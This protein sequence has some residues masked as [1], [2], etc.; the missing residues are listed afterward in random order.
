MSIRPMCRLPDDFAG[1][2]V[3][4]AINEYYHAK[5]LQV[6]RLDYDVENKVASSFKHFYP[7]LERP[8]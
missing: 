7:D 1:T 8:A 5:G 3:A 6:Q 4:V 2:T